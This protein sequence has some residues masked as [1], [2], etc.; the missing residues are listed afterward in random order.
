MLTEYFRRYAV[1]SRKGF[2]ALL[3]IE[4]LPDAQQARRLP[5]FIQRRDAHLTSSGG[6]APLTPLCLGERP[7]HD[8]RLFSFRRLSPLAS[9][10][11][12]SWR[13]AL[14]VGR[15]GAGLDDPRSGRSASPMPTGKRNARGRHLL[16]AWRRELPQPEVWDGN[17]HHP[18]RCWRIVGTRTA[19]LL[20][21]YSVKEAATDN[22]LRQLF[23][24]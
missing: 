20:T 2:G 4:V 1:N 16:L 13:L 17:C 15:N 5:E 22:R 24:C 3:A 9:G 14:P 12:R 19:I 10:K 11:P 23:Q 18:L 7:M 21:T 8:G 6:T